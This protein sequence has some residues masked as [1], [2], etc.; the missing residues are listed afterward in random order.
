[1]SFND[2]SLLY[3]Q[4][5]FYIE[6]EY[7]HGKKEVNKIAFKAFLTD[8]K[9]KFASVWKDEKVYGRI[10]P[11]YTFQNTT[12]TISLAW[13]TP[14]ASFKESKE[15][16][17]KVSRLMRFLYPTYTNNGDATTLTKPP[18]LRM[19]FVNLAKVD[20]D[21]G[22]LGKVDGFD[23]SP[24]MEA[25]WWDGDL[26]AGGMRLVNTL[27]AKTLN[28]SCNFSVIHEEPLGWNNGTWEVVADTPEFGPPQPPLKNAFPFMPPYMSAND[29]LGL[30]PP[31]APPTDE[32][33][34]VTQEEAD[35]M[36]PDPAIAAALA[37]QEQADLDSTS[38]EYGASTEVSFEEQWMPEL[39]EASI[40]PYEEDADAE[41]LLGDPLGPQFLY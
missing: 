5:G 31:P 33:T 30:K 7:F 2:P 36:T 6:F 1:M 26:E 34:S 12:R 25:G 11:I 9:D 37:A 32:G 27:Y 39:D 8:Y 24:D 4:K 14:S 38:D 15:N 10:D 21:K 40:P 17:A 3:A 29:T 19:R 23:F 16:M 22:L 13:D 18:L 28:F 35:Q 20:Y 41:A